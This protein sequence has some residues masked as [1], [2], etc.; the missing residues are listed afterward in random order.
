MISLATSV[1]AE[2]KSACAFLQLIKEDFLYVKAVTDAKL[3]RPETSVHQN[4][5]WDFHPHAISSVNKL[6]QPLEQ[7]RP[8]DQVFPVP[9]HD[10]ML[11]LATGK[12]DHSRCRY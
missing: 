3:M 6:S 5:T 2:S 1:Q 12:H 11:C 8:A 4:C 10:Y 9:I 7:L